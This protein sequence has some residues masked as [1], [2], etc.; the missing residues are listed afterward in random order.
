MAHEGGWAMTSWQMGRRDGV[1]SRVA[2]L[3]RASATAVGS[4]S[5]RGKRGR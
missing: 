3:L 4:N 1:S 5:T 2:A